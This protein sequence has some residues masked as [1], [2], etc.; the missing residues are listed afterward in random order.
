MIFY[1]SGTTAIKPSGQGVLMRRVV[2][3]IKDRRAATA[4]EY[5][6]ILSLIFLAMVAAVRGVANETTTMWNN[7]SNAVTKR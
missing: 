6:L 4:V 1:F 7:V 2:D 3:L 5:G